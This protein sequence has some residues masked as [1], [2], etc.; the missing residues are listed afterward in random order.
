M[1]NTCRK[2]VGAEGTIYQSDAINWVQ[3]LTPMVFTMHRKAGRNVKID[4]VLLLVGGSYH[5][6]SIDSLRMF[7]NGLYKAGLI[8]AMSL[9][10]MEGASRARTSIDEFTAQ[11]FVRF[12][13][14]KTKSWS[15]HVSQL[16]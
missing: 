6:T 15:N 16:D 4:T 8:Q 14:L 12:H 11:A 9:N 10:V 7:W 3:I 2:Q 5:R 1:Q 13:S